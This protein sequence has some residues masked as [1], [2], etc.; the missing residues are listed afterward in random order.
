MNIPLIP[1]VHVYTCTYRTGTAVP[2]GTRVRTNIHA[3]SQKRLEIQA[4]RCKRGHEWVVPW[5][6]HVRT[7]TTRVRTRVRIAIPLV[8][9]YVHVYVRTNITFS[10][11]LKNDLK[12]KHSD[13]T[14][15]LSG[16]RVLLQ[17][18]YGHTGIDSLHEYPCICVSMLTTPKIF[19]VEP[20]LY[21]C[22]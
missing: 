9:E 21:N 17:Y 7:Y 20:C 16:T 15:T 4:L 13:A 14:G 6:V 3:L 12:Y 1:M 19:P 2:L 18:R 5:Y 22:F 8:L 10:H 11:S